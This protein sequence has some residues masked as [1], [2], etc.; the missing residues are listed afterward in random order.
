M[1][2]RRRVR[3]KK[4]KDMEK[5]HRGDAGRRGID[6]RKNGEVQQ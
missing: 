4:R 6:K 5:I 3:R 1:E 2:E